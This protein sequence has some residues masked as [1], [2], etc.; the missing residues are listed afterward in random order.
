MP[1]ACVSLAQGCVPS[2]LPGIPSTLARVSF[3]LARAPFAPAARLSLALAAVLSLSVW[4]FPPGS[5]AAVQDSAA[6][7]DSA[8]LRI[9]FLDV[10]QADAV[11]IQAPEGQTALVDAGRRSPVDGLRALGVEEI[12]L[13][14]ATHAHADHIGGMTDVLDAFPVRYFM[15]NAMPHTTRTYQRLME[16]VERRSDVTYLAPEPPRRIALGAASIEAL[17]LPPPRARDQNNRSVT[18]VVRHG[19][20]SAFLS[21]DSEE[22]QLNFLTAVG[23]VHP[24]TLLKAPHHGSDNGFTPAFLQVARPE[25]V[26]ISVGERNQYGH[27]GPQALAAFSSIAREV[28]RTDRDGT[29]TVLGFPDGAHRVTLEDSEAGRGSC[30]HHT[31]GDSPPGERP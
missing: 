31:L 8:A 17:P 16:E 21:G 12:D 29:V 11:L 28:Y 2:V 1:M 30:G 15:D 10:G 13:L 24:M 5:A 7:Q 20:F 22:R 23:A 19:R 25:V 4:A 27:P 6:A 3:A 9:T 26:V 14:V 18:L